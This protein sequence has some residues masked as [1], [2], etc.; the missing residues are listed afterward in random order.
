MAHAG[1]ERFG[2][3]AS[4]LAGRTVD[5]EAA[6]AGERTWTDGQR[7]LIDP[8]LDRT[9]IVRGLSLQAC[10]IAADS[11][12]PQVLADLARRPKLRRRY[13]HVEGARALAAQYDLLPPSVRAAIDPHWAAGTDSPLQSLTIAAS[14][15]TIEDPPLWFGE[16]RP[17]AIRVEPATDSNETGPSG[18]W[19]EPR[20]GDAEALRALEDEAMDDTA[21]D[22]L[23]SPVGGGG[24]IGRLLGRLLS[25]ARGSGGGPPGADTPTHRA[26]GG[27]RRRGAVRSTVG[28]PG[29][30]LDGPAG[31]PHHADAVYPEWDV[32]RQRYRPDWCTV[33]EMPMPHQ[34]PRSTVLP[35]SH[36]TRRALGRVGLSLEPLGRQ[37]EG[38]DIDID[39][40]VEARVNA[41]AGTPTEEGAY[42]DMV[43]RRRDLAVLVLLDVS[44]S[45]GE[46]AAVGGTVHAHQQAATARV[47]RA[48]H[49]IGARVALYGFRSQGRTSVQILP[50]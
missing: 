43:R 29:G 12:A 11:L 6:S 30:A 47:A 31:I 10:L 18:L 39:A 28:L 8:D 1:L 4:A 42:V 25:D 34:G 23:S 46:P 22:Q 7:I 44:G 15:A 48:L 24:G 33:R 45:G 14:R 27:G 36:A 40:A 2:L 17:W 3:L 16:L 49:E 35:D 37:L 19:H 9:E 26:A 41:L 38:V 50:F 13:L 20:R 21:T 32:H 5:V